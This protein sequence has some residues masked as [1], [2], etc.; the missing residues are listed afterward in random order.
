MIRGITG[1]PFQTFGAMTD[2]F[3]PEVRS[4][5][6]YT[7]SVLSNGV[8]RRHRYGSRGSGNEIGTS[9]Y[10][11]LTATAASVDRSLAAENGKREL[12]PMWYLPVENPVRY[13][14]GGHA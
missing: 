10:A 3:Q 5:A 6:W 4:D 7:N 9:T 11:R 12:K 13:D 1:E 14:R 2:Y 8:D